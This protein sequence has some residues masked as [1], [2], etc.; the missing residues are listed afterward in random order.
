M[1]NNKFHIPTEMQPLWP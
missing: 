1:N